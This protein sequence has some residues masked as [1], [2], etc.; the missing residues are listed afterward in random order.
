MITPSWIDMSS[1]NFRRLPTRP[2]APRRMHASLVAARIRGRG[3]LR[4][5]MRRHASTLFPSPRRKS[6]FDS[7][8]L[9]T[10]ASYNIAAAYMINYKYDDLLDD[11]FDYAYGEEGEA[12]GLI[13]PDY[14]FAYDYTYFGCSLPH[15]DISYMSFNYPLID[16]AS[17]VISGSSITV[18]EHVGAVSG[19]SFDMLYEND[20][21]VLFHGSDLKKSSWEVRPSSSLP[22]RSSLLPPP[23]S[24][25]PSSSSP[26]SSSSSSSHATYHLWQDAEVI[27]ATQETVDATIKPS[28][29]FLVAVGPRPPP[30]PP[31][32]PPASSPPPSP[33]YMGLMCICDEF[34]NGAD[35]TPYAEVCGLD[36]GGTNCYPPQADGCGSATACLV[37]PEGYNGPHFGCQDH[38]SSKKCSK[39]VRAGLASP[40]LASR[41]SLVLG[42]HTLRLHAAPRR[43]PPRSSSSSRPLAP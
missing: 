29:S 43:R 42:I 36:Q 35:E 1:S 28:D 40:R 7:A 19:Y 2:L 3:Q 12:N 6:D 31:S 34:R 22:L 32:P 27:G 15:C 24:S 41:L 4:T 18:F 10:I 25:S 20:A 26:S 8:Y 16:P 21:T 30:S 33:P 14:S 23:S 13:P 39:N 17:V 37:A 38:L 5:G 11:L 9:Y